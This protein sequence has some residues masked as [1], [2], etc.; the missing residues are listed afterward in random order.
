MFDSR[1]LASIREAVRYAEQRLIEPTPL[2]LFLC[3]IRKSDDTASLIDDRD[4]ERML[5]R[6]VLDSARPRQDPSVFQL[7]LERAVQFGR[8]GPTERVRPIDLI[9]SAAEIARD[10]IDEALRTLGTTSSHLIARLELDNSV[11]DKDEAPLLDQVQPARYAVVVGG[12]GFSDDRNQYQTLEQAQRVQRILRAR[13]AKEPMTE[14]IVGT[15]GYAL[16]QTPER[17]GDA[18]WVEIRAL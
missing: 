16:F 17:L 2:L 13:I 11:V 7:V 18:R 3:A 5:E 6:V 14:E 9:R 15:D 10:E 4:I 8:E 12:D 1:G